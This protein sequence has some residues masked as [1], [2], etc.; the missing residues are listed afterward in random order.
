M[1]VSSERA[2]ISPLK[3]AVCGSGRWGQTL[4]RNITAAPD[5]EL[6]AVI[7]TRS[8]I[9]DEIIHGAPVFG[10]W[11]LAVSRMNLDGIV[12]AL[13]PGRQPA[14]AEEI[15]ESGMPLFLEKPLALNVEAAKRLVQ[16]AGDWGFVGLVD[17]LHLFAPEFQELVRQVRGRGTVRSITSVSGNHGPYRDSWSVCWDW[18]PHDVAMVLTVMESVP[19]SVTACIVDRIDKGAQ[20]YENVRLILTFADGAVADITTGN[21]FDRRR[22]E[23]AVA[24][25]DFTVSYAENPEN[26]RSLAMGHGNDARPVQVESVPPLTAALKVFAERVR[27]G[28][29]GEADLALGAQVVRVISA[30]E[31]AISGGVAVSIGQAAYSATS[32]AAG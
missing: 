29:G 14:V 32:G 12:L 24:V 7:S 3:L 11:R 4:M 23:F 28:A 13:P 2:D 20:T 30:A 17:H 31:R 25:D 19:V 1:T 21:A 15:I 16:A 5:L 27:Q 10:D 6:A 8:S 9:P 18:A 26:E 22:R